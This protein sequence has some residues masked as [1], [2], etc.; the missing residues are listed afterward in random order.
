M[1]TISLSNIWLI[2]YKL[3]NVSIVARYS[4]ST[5]KSWLLSVPDMYTYTDFKSSFIFYLISS[6]S[7]LSCS[8]PGVFGR[9]SFYPYPSVC[10]HWRWYN[11][12]INP[13]PK[14][15]PWRIWICI[16]HKL[17]MDLNKTRLTYMHTY[18]IHCNS[19]TVSLV[20]D[21]TNL[22]W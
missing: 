2:L 1:C 16:S 8:V 5:L 6:E 21:E 18:G 15:Q 20:R 19:L 11:Y 10:V 3:R 4:P 22:G 13:V 7:I 17:I 12:T 9:E 14:K